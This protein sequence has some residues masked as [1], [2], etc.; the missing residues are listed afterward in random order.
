MVPKSVF[1]RLP[2]V[3]LAVVGFKI[4]VTGILTVSLLSHL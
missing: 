4:M 3:N 2:C 1:E